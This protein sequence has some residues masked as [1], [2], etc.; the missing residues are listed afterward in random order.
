MLWPEAAE[1]VARWPEQPAEEEV[2]V[3]EGAGAE[4]AEP[5]EEEDLV[6]GEEEGEEEVLMGET[7]AQVG[8]APLIHLRL[9]HLHQRIR[10]P[11]SILKRRPNPFI[12]KESSRLHPPIPVLHFIPSPEIHPR[13]C[14]P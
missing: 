12:S 13:Y 1:A 2:A 4:E 14:I 9:T 6:E 10:I 7:W 11:V 8:L 3:E 5:E